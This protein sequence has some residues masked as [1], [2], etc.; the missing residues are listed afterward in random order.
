MTPRSM[1]PG[2]CSASISL[3]GT[4]AVPG[5]L[6]IAAQAAEGRAT[7]RDAWVTDVDWTRIATWAPMAIAVLL[8]LA[9][10]WRDRGK[11]YLAD[12]PE[13]PTIDCGTVPIS[14][15]RVRRDA[16]RG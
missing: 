13:E 3:L 6:S 5:L 12:E 16:D 9:A 10:F 7:V 2:R 14:L 11:P 8:V 1:M 15:E 4:S